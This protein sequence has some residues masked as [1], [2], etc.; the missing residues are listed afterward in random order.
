MLDLV[1]KKIQVRPRR[2]KVRHL[3]LR[4]KQNDS[5]ADTAAAPSEAADATA[6]G[7]TTETKTLG[8]TGAA[9]DAA[10]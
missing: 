8:T 4:S 1:M 5:C 2:T 7:G 3:N 10:A 9:E 6:F